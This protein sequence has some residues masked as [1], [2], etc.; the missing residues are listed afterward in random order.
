MSDVD[1]PVIPSFFEVKFFQN[2]RRVPICGGAFSEVSG[3]EA[4]MEP[5]A[6]REGGRYNGEVQRAGQIT[7]ATVIL[8]RGLTP[9]SHLWNWFKL[10]ANGHTA[11]RMRAEL[12]QLRPTA[13]GGREVAL[14]WVMQNALPTKFKAATYTSTA[15]EVGI[16]ELHFVHEGL[17]MRSGAGG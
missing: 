11:V 12:V 8:K 9:T 3:L 16:E 2:G 13:S 4:T 10:L 7:Y 15:A 5:K 6:I 1:W 14:R 17:T